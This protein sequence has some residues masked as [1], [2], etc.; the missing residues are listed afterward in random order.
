MKNAVHQAVG[1]AS[2][3]GAA[4]RRR[5]RR[6]SPQPPLDVKR[7]GASMSSRLAPSSASK[8]SR[9]TG[10]VHNE[11]LIVRFGSPRRRRGRK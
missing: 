2:A 1:Q 11:P 5:R 6:P 7:R 9:F 10:S 3:A 8:A 4:A